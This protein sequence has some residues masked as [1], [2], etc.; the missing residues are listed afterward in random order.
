MFH[1]LKDVLNKKIK[2]DVN[3]KVFEAQKICEDYQKIIRDELKTDKINVLSVRNGILT[4]N[5][6]NKVF[7]NEIQLKKEAILIKIN[8]NKNKIKNIKL[9]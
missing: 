6:K 4:I 7:I 1:N 2:K 9:A 3:F 5:C 8:S